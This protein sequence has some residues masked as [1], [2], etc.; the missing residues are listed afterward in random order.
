MAGHE[1]TAQAL[2]W[3]WSAAPGGG[4]IVTPPALLGPMRKLLNG[5]AIRY[6]LW[7]RVAFC[8]TA[9]IFLTCI[10]TTDHLSDRILRGAKPG[11]LPV[12]FPTKFTLSVHL[13]TAKAMGLKI[14]ESFLLRADEQIE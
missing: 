13:T 6:Q 4:L 9:P 5:L 14:P 7:R 10:G 1:T 3:T 12:Q 8:L 2:A 11:N